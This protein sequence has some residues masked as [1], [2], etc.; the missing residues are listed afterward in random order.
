MKNRMTATACSYETGICAGFG[1][2]EDNP[3]AEAC[4][5]AGTGLLLRVNIGDIEPSAGAIH[6]SNVKITTRNY[7]LSSD[8]VSHVGEIQFPVPKFVVEYAD[9]TMNTLELKVFS[10]LNVP[11]SHFS[12]QMQGIGLKQQPVING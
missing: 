7:R 4:F 12:F 6:L 9:A 1:T 3:N 8:D 2:M 11:L 5:M 10:D